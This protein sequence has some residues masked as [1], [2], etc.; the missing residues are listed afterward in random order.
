MTTLKKYLALEIHYFLALPLMAVSWFSV[1]LYVKYWHFLFCLAF[2]STLQ[3]PVIPL[4]KYIN[5]SVWERWEMNLPVVLIYSSLYLISLSEPDSIHR[6]SCAPFVGLVW[7]M[8]V[9]E[10]AAQGLSVR[11]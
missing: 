5:A 2:S 6:A 10:I 1:M 8:K 7:E 11:S 3:A 9:V 4:L